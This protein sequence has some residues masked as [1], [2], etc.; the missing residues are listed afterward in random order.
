MC[1]SSVSEEGEHWAVLK[2]VFEVRDFAGIRGPADL[3][4]RV[5]LTAGLAIIVIMLLVRPRT[6]VSVSSERSPEADSV[7]VRACH[8]DPE[9][10]LLA[11]RSTRHSFTG[12]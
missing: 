10:I 9:T 1:D 6:L 12:R 7:R 5:V 8:E 3:D 11:S 2:D 4:A